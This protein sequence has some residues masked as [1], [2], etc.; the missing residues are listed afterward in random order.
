MCDVSVVYCVMC[1]W[2]IAERR[3]RVHTLCLPVTS[4][5]SDVFL[6][7]N[8]YAIVGLLSKM[9]M[10]SCYALIRPM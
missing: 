6:N 7:A 4:T 1:L 5:L 10:I 3:I 2:C 9:G 8:Q